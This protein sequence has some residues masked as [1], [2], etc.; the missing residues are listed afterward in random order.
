[1]ETGATDAGVNDR[2]RRGQTLD[3]LGGEF[4]G[5]LT[6]R[7]REQL[8]PVQDR[9]HHRGFPLGRIELQVATSG[10]RDYFRIHRDSDGGDTR[11]L[12]FVYFFFPEPRRFSGGELRVFDTEVRDGELVPTDRSQTVVPRSNLAVFFP[13][14]HDHEVLPVRVPTNSFADGRFTVT[15]WIHRE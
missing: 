5:L 8:E 14:R 3:D 9:L 2:I 1:V 11:E 6:E 4:H 10:D 7:V 15:G 13:S 12:S